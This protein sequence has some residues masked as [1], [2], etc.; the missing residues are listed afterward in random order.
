MKRLSVP[1]IAFSL[2]SFAGLSKTATADP[3]VVS[4]ALSVVYGTITST[5]EKKSLGS[6]PVFL[7]NTKTRQVI[8][9]KTDL[10]G[11]YIFSDLPPGTYRIRAGGG[12][13]SIAVKVG[14]LT[15]G[16]VGE[17]D[18]QVEPLSRGNAS[19]SGEVEEGS[20]KRSFPV[21]A[22]ITVE[23]LQLKE[24]YSIS[25]NNKGQF[26]LKEIPPGKYRVQ[27]MKSGDL[28]LLLDLSVSGETKETFL[29]RRSRLAQADINARGDKKIKDSTGAITIV[30]RKKFVQYQTAG[31]GFVL[32]QTPSVNYYSRSGMNDITGGMEYF[33]CRGYTAGGTNSS[34]MG[35]SNVEFSIAGVPMNQ[36]GDGGQIYGMPVV[37][38]DISSMDVQRGVTTSEQLGNYASGCAVNFHLVAPSREAGSTITSG[39]GNYGLYY[40]SFAT[41]SGLNKKVNGAG[42]NDLTVLN[43]NGFQEFTSYQEFQD[44]GNLTKYLSNGY[45]KLI[46]LGAYQN[47]DR[48]SSTSL[49]NFNTFGPTY[50]GT[51]NGEYPQAPSGI[52]N[53]DSPYYKNWIAQRYVI[54]LKSD[55]QINDNVRVKNNA[56]AFLIPYG[57]IQAPV[58]Q[59]GSQNVSGAGTYTTYTPSYNGYTGGAT[60]PNGGS[61]GSPFN[62]DVVQG[63]GFKVGDIARTD[64]RLW[65]HDTLHLGFRLSDYNVLFENEPGFSN[66]VTGSGDNFSAEYLTVGGYLEDHWRPTDQWLFSAGFRVMSGGIQASDHLS[67][68]QSDFYLNPANGAGPINGGVTAGETFDVV[69]PHAGIDYYPTENLK[70]YASAGQSF[71]PPTVAFWQGLTSSQTPLSI[72]PEIITDYQVG[73]RYD[74]RQGFVALDAY[75]DEISNMF[76]TSLVIPS[77]GPAYSVPTTAGSAQIQGIEGEFKEELGGGFSVDGNYSVTNATFLSMVYG[78]GGNQQAGTLNPTSFSTT[79]DR[80]PFIPNQIANLDLN[81]NRGPWHLTVNERYTGDTNVIDT[82]G[83]PKGN[84]NNIP[85]SGGSNNQITAPGYFVTNLI[86]GYDLPESTWYKK[87]QLFFNAFNLLNTN[88]YNPAFLSPGYNNVETLMVYPGEPI[89]VFGGVSVSF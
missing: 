74:T 72:H 67:T 42:Y 48:G 68:A 34:P 73:T 88:Y 35:M 16:T 55:N 79:G 10:Q 13:Y 11:D 56:F 53:P 21:S 22:R 25:S 30:G 32:N 12:V 84:A 71:T 75:D 4:P 5:K 43:M 80:I 36:S 2:L 33:V 38:N 27:I 15:P 57:V 89:N 54:S 59:T 18:L 65:S 6:V 77:S 49:Q 64:I 70:I 29:L 24:I 63:Q 28:P 78:G 83:G 45:V 23:N 19:L 26:V 82:T 76:T 8:M 61:L 40:T 85:G 44:Y 81:Y 3:G 87:A 41:N 39:M 62:F 69:L 47:Y 46:F 7:E 50:S 31:P 86:V 60:G 37:S 66:N 58:V 52:N 1:L 20:R 51:P 17:I 9:K 14:V